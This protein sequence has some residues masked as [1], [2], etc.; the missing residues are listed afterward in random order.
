MAL[1]LGT[2]QALKQAHAETTHGDAHAGQQQDR[3][4]SNGT[5]DITH[6]ANGGGEHGAD[7]SQQGSNS[8]SRRRSAAL[9]SSMISKQ[10]PHNGNHH[11]EAD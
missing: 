8:H 9:L 1:R 2:Q 10:A 3:L 11:G 5:G 7:G 6:P 4:V